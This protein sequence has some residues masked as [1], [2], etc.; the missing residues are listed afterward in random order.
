MPILKGHGGSAGVTFGFKNHFGSI[1]RGPSDLHD[2]TYI[3]KG[4]Y[5][6]PQYSPMVDIWKN[7]NIRDKTVLILGDAIFAQ[8][9]SN[10]GPPRR[11]N[12]FN[13]DSPNMILLSVD[14][15]AIDSVMYDYF[16]REGSPMSGSDD[17]LRSAAQEGLGVFEH[18]NNPQDKE[19]SV[20]DYVHL[21]LDQ[22]SFEK[23]DL[24]QDGNVDVL[25]LQL[26]MN[27]FLGVETDPTVVERADVNE[28][29]Q[30]DSEDIRQILELILGI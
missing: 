13:N 18:W 8:W 26:C 15:V 4:A 11:W 7:P 14:P 21:D 16:E 24:N 27:V 28:D 12:S 17:Y 6:H 3:T 10:A 1:N 23:E 25:D 9:P 19:Y 30:V 29:G 5:Y 2:Y 22:P 20:I